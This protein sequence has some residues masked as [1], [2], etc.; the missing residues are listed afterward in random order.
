MSLEERRKLFDALDSKDSPAPE[1]GF[2]VLPKGMH[3]TLVEKFQELFDLYRK[4]I[5]QF[6]QLDKEMSRRNR[7]SDPEIILRNV[8]I[9]ELHE[10]K[11]D[12]WTRG[13]L[14]QTY[15]LHKSQIQTILRNRIMGA[16]GVAV[17]FSCCFR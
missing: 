3:D 14:A 12:Y 10:Q 15:K 13:K 17:E 8:K 6:G 4:S 9:I 1:A 16:A 11:P 7:P 5:K 2:I